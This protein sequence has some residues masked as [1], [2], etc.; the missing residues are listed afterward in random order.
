ME[1]I[2]YTFT[3]EQ[4]QTTLNTAKEVVISRLATE[5][6]LD[7]ELYKALSGSLLVV[8]AK[9][10]WFGEFFD[11]VRGLFSGPKKEGVCQVVTIF[12][13]TVFDGYMRKQREEKAGLNASNQSSSSAT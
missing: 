4:L 12:D 7:E 11:A 10:G 5:G 1:S 2:V 3:H 8:A 13:K 9:K 6:F